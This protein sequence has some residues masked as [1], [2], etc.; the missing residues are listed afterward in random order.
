MTGGG[1]G[2]F[3]KPGVNTTLVA[4]PPFNQIDM[5]VIAPESYT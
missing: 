5:G 1:D 4:V 3:Q 2:I